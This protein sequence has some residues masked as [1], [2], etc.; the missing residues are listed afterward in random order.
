VYLDPYT[1]RAFEKP[2][3]YAGDAVMIDYLYEPNYEN[4]FRDEFNYVGREIFSYTTNSVPARAVRYRRKYIADVIDEICLANG[5]ETNVLSVAAGHFREGDTS[6]AIKA[7]MF[8]SIVALDQDAESLDV[9]D[10]EYGRYGVSVS[11]SNLL[12]L[13]AGKTKFADLDFVYSAGLFDYLENKVAKRAVKAFFSALRSGGEMLITNFNLNNSC[14]GY[15]ESF[16]DWK[17]IYRD[18]KEM[19]GLFDG[20]VGDRDKLTCLFDPTTSLVF[21]RAK[22]A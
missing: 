14:R 9:V 12:S 17:L 13:I 21:A 2:R 20:V 7:G 4:L 11:D 1:K 5:T 8:N 19:L 22:K 18:T 3:G 10:R 16:M 15:M 6:Q